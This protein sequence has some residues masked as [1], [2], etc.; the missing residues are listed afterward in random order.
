MNRRAEEQWNRWRSQ[1]LWDP[2]LCRETEELARR[3]EQAKDEE[4]LC[5]AEEE[6]NDRFYRDLT[7]G[8]GGL[9]GVIG[10]GTN[11]MN[12]YTVAKATQGCAN[13]LKRHFLR[14]SAAIA[15]DSRVKSEL[16]AR[17]TAE[18]FAAN[19]VQVHIFPELMPTPALSF[20]VRHLHCSGG[21]VITASHNPAKYNGYKVYG[22]DGCQ[23]TAGAAEEILG[24]IEQVELFAPLEDEEERQENMPRTASVRRMEFEAGLASGQISY[25]GEDTVTA[26]INAVSAQSLCGD[27]IMDKAVS[28]VYTPLNGTGLK[29]VTRCLKENGFTRLSVVAEQAQ[30]DGSFP[31]CPYPNPEVQEAMELGLRDARRLGSDLLLATDPDCDRVGIAVRD[32]ADYVRLNANE[33]GLLLLDYICRRRMALNRMPERPVAMKTI[34]TVDLAKQVAA[35]YGVEMIDVLTGFKYIGEQIGRLE[36]QGEEERFLFGFEESYGYLTGGYVRDK[37]GVD[38]SLMICEMAAYYRTRGQSLLDVL[39]SIYQRYGYCMNTQHSF[40]LEGESGFEKMNAIMADFRSAPPKEM[41]GKRILEIQDFQRSQ[42]CGADGSRKELHLPQSNVL[43]YQ[44]EGG[45]SV[46][47]RP[48]GTEPKLKVYVSVN[49]K[50]QASAAELERR[51]ARELERRLKV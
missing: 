6:I 22:S 15:Y 3:W 48:S 45:S 51:L 33:T 16:F 29:C 43:K 23:I 26:Y 46:V 17:V 50:D 41:A 37:D 10:A 28:I 8:T 42:A 1:R 34:V 5:Q 21:V 30:P 2:S 4:T 35:S 36:A 12:V 47:I 24:E 18:V 25:I 40:L 13:Y 20:A 9:R 7:F 39:R 49:E 32:G 27:E 14:P 11:R 19:G 38:A 44:L 31:T